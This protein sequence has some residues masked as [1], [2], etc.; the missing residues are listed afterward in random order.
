[1]R[2]T[3]CHFGENTIPALRLEEEESAMCG[4]TWAGQGGFLTWFQVWKVR[5]QTAL[6]GRFK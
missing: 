3:G 1:M 6:S 5:W 2:K 4:P